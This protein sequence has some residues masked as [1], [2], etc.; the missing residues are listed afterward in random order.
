MPGPSQ[1]RVPS[2]E[3]LSISWAADSCDQV[4]NAQIHTPDERFFE[5]AGEPE[6]RL[7]GAFCLVQLLSDSFK[8]ASNARNGRRSFQ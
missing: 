5:E 4:Q 8:V 2:L 7:R 3:N 1:S 6:G